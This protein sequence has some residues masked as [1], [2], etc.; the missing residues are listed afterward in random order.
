VT[1]EPRNAFVTDPQFQIDIAREIQRL[2]FERWGARHETIIIGRDATLATVLERMARI[3]ASDGPVLITGE[4]GTGKEL[5]ARA[6][7]VLCHRRARPFIA[8]NCAQYHDG[9]LLASELFGH[10]RGSFTGAIA[11]HKGVF[12]ECNGGV[13]FLDEIGE[14]SLPAQAML[15]RAL[16]EGEIMPVGSTRAIQVDVRVF[17]ATS[18]NLWAMVESGRFREDLYYRLRYLHVA[19]PPVRERGRDW[20]LISTYYLRRLGDRS[21]VHKTLSP[22]AKELMR[23]YWWPGNIRE[24]KAVVDAGFHLSSGD[25]IDER[26]VGEQLDWRTGRPPASGA[27]TSAVEE[28]LGRLT[29]GRGNFWEVV[30]EP[31]MNRELCRADAREVIARGLR[32]SAGSYKR[33]VTLF[34]IRDGDYI[35]FMDFLR[36][37]KLKPEVRSP[38]TGGVGTAGPRSPTA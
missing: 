31:F 16:G 35:K 5:V 9:Q 19:V 30:Y 25:V 34:G 10:R 23:E 2:S 18:R 24:L 22:A 28:C 37:Q 13:V 7:C 36:H 32:Q 6:L 12:E 33:L 15:L 17:A 29:E 21:T 20:E 3:A 38:V 26:D 4:T 1:A 27:T 14:L 11:D 8:I